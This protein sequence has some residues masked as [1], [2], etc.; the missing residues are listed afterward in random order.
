MLSRVWIA[1]FCIAFSS[2]SLAAGDGIIKKQS[3]YSVTET[4][5]RLENILKKKGISVAV[6]WDHGRKAQQAG[7]TLPET[8]ILI[9]GNPKLG[10]P[11]M[12][13]NQQ[14]GL[15]LPMKALAYKDEQ[16][17]VWL[18]YNDPAYLKQRHGI[19]KHD[20]IFKKMSA[21]LNKLTNKAVNP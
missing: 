11:L 3:Q 7:I 15:D 5:D 4:L 8:E 19:T 14:I 10:S 9:F 13:S 18:V 21:A 1:V 16:G 20:P 12:Q 2:L 6:R 17:K